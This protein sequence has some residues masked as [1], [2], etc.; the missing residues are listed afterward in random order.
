MKSSATVDIRDGCYYYDRYL[1]FKIT[2]LI[3]AMTSFDVN[4]A[5]DVIP[6]TS[7]A[8]VGSYFWFLVMTLMFVYVILLYLVAIHACPP[9][10]TR[11]TYTRSHDLLVNMCVMPFGRLVDTHILSSCHVISS[12]LYTLAPV[13]FTHPHSHIGQPE[14]KSVRSFH[15]SLNLHLSVQ[16]F[17]GQ[18]S[19]QSTSMSTSLSTCKVSNSY[20]AMKL[21]TSETT[22]ST[23]IE[24]IPFQKFRLS[25]CRWSTP[26]H[27][28]QLCLFWSVFVPPLK[29]DVN[30]LVQIIKLYLNRNQ[31]KMHD[32]IASIRKFYTRRQG[33]LTSMYARYSAITGAIPPDLIFKYSFAIDIGLG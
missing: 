11:V 12:P 26:F 20:R 14:P 1:W 8:C 16:L 25:T 19:D 28:R 15:L 18:Q 31:C 32:F 2:I 33:H 30:T 3:L 17:Y 6:H 24:H 10:D 27:K 4:S 21:S 7:L 22:C 29:D 23:W 9:V 5:C 13:V